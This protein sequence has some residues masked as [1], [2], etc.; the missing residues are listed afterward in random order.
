MS[1]LIE[2]AI[3]SDAGEQA[4]KIIQQ[5]LGIETDEVVNYCFPQHWPN[6]REQRAKNHR[7]VAPDRSAVSRLT[8][9]SPGQLK[10]PE[11]D[12]SD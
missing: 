7:R 10:Q 12:A 2:Q 4:A 3:D 5:A 9:A 1:N 8:Q 6:D 11:G